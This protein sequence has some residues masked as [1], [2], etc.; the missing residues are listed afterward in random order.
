MAIARRLTSADCDA[1]GVVGPSGRLGWVEETWLGPSEDVSAFVVRLSDGR[2][3]LLLA[4]DV[5]T[6]LPDDELVVVSEDVSLLR[7]E[8]PHLDPDANGGP[9][10]ASWRA[11]GEALPLPEPAHGVRGLVGARR[12]PRVL[13]VPRPAAAERPVWQ[14][15]ALLYGTVTLIV[16]VLIALDL[17]LSYVFA[18]GPPY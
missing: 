6:V 9:P 1:F 2:R 11:S 4:D 10:A 8:P 13:T 15:I 7:L 3:G 17:L 18:G 5:Q 12:R 14:T 16:L